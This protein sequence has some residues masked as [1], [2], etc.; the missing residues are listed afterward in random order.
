MWLPQPEDVGA[1][2]LHYG[3]DAES[4]AS[5]VFRRRRPLYLRDRHHLKSEQESWVMIDQRKALEFKVGSQLVGV[6][7]FSRSL[8]IG[9]LTAWNR[10]DALHHEVLSPDRAELI[11]RTAQLLS[12]TSYLRQVT[13]FRDQYQ[14]VAAHCANYNYM[15]SQVDSSDLKNLKDESKYIKLLN[16]L[17]TLIGIRRVR[18][19]FAKDAF[20]LTGS[21]TGN[22][23]FQC[24][25]SVDE[26]GAVDGHIQMENSANNPFVKYV[27]QRASWSQSAMLLCPDL[28]NAESAPRAKKGHDAGTAIDLAAES[29]GRDP[30]VSWYVAPITWCTEFDAAE[31]EAGWSTEKRM[32]YGFFSIDNTQKADGSAADNDL[33]QS[34][35]WHELARLKLTWCATMLGYHLGRGGSK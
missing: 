30:A 17:K 35:T 18:L 8:P 33:P 29:L 15:L 28:L 21:A 6:P 23:V 4:F 3:F 13:Q 24:Y 16:L 27:I 26:S 2:P 7:L 1:K 5:M 14:L 11:V 12:R 31:T 25:G 32:M 9:V 22:E 20:T 34:R 19:F 10:E